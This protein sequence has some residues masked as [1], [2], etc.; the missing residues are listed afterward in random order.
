SSRKAFAQVPR[1]SA[2]CGLHPKSLALG[3][4]PFLP[5]ALPRELCSLLRATLF[6]RCTKANAAS[7]CSMTRLATM[8]RHCCRTSGCPKTTSL[9]T[10][11]PTRSPLPAWTSTVVYVVTPSLFFFSLV[12]L[13]IPLPQHTPSPRPPQHACRPVWKICSCPQPSPSCRTPRSPERWR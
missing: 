11:S 4:T 3:H 2:P 10:T 13:A 8:H 1:A 9:T 5:Q 6:A 7:W 12:V